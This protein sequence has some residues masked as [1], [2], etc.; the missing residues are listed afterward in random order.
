[1]NNRR[2]FTLIELLVV[3]AIIAILAAILF[4]VFA[5]ARASARQ[6]SCLSNVKQYTLGILMYYQDY[7][8]RIANLDMN[9]AAQPN[10]GDPGTDP[11]APPSMFA[12][13]IQ[14]YIKTQALGYCPEIGRTKWA[15]AIPDPAIYGQAYVAALEQSGV[16]YGCFAQMAVNI[17]MIDWGIN[18]RLSKVQRPA[19]VMLLTA[20]STWDFG[21][22]MGYGIGNTGVWPGNPAGDNCGGPGDGWTW[23]VHRASGRSGQ[24][25]AYSGLANVG[26]VDGHAKA[27]KFGDLMRCE[28]NVAL[29]AWYYPH[30]DAR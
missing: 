16:Y 28:E 10:W 8:E 22:S 3:I 21:P 23:F 24:T 2:G 5:Q 30:W 26:F 29:G 7:S 19:E 27:V 4:P 17:W 1:M 20:E 18:G 25:S 6:T 15:S 12:N 11:N 9:G 13:T 14:P